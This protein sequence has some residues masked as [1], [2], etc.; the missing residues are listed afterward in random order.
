VTRAT[1]VD[2]IDPAGEGR[3]MVD[4]RSGPAGRSPRWARTATLMAGPGRGTWFVPDVGDEVL[5]AFEQGDPAHPIV[6][7]SLWSATSMPPEQIGTDNARRAIVTRSGARILVDDTNGQCVISLETPN[8]QKVTLDDGASGTITIA[9][10]SGNSVELA[11]TGVSVTAAA[12]VNVAATS[13]TVT[14]SKIVLDSG[15]VTVAGV[16][17]CSTMIADSVVATSYTPGAGNIW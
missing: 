16:M 3:V 2:N 8:G 5:I 7:G 9:D 10:Q 14:A 13:V 12:E 4:L 17:K 15:L 6:V 1:V 11:T